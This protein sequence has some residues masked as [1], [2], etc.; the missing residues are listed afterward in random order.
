MV[1]FGDSTSDPGSTPGIS[2]RGGGEGGETDGVYG[3]EADRVYGGEADGE[4]G[5]VNG[6]EAD[7]VHGGEATWTQPDLHEIPVAPGRGARYQ[8]GVA[9]RDTL[10]T[11]GSHW[12]TL[13]S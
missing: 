3:G 1:C 13:Q 12:V 4:A 6:G 9:P 2:T 11:T 7:G 5:G 8:I 10:V